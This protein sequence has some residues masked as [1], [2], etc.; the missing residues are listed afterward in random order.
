MGSSS[1]SIIHIHTVIC[2][3]QPCVVRV[4]DDDDD[5]KRGRV[6]YLA[7]DT[8]IRAVRDRKWKTFFLQELT[9]M[10][11]LQNSWSRNFVDLIYIRREYAVFEMHKHCLL[12]P[13]AAESGRKELVERYVYVGKFMCANALGRALFDLLK[14]VL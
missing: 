11:E 3:C 12:R 14:P 1:S 4:F 13:C 9:D 6:R 5:G 10:L 2:I 7:D 8:A